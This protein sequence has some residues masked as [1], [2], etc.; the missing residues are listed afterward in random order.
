MSFR[1]IDEQKEKELEQQK[2]VENALENTRIYAK[3][4][5]ENLNIINDII[6]S[7]LWYM[8]FD[9]SGN[10]NRCV[11]SDTFRKM[12]GFN[13]IY[14]FPD[15][16]ESWSDRLHPEERDRI[17]EAY[18]NCVAGKGDY[19]VQYRLLKKDN[20]YTWYRAVGKVVRYTNGKPRLFAGTVVDI[21]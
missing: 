12:L 1:C 5:Q 9:E 7:G 19:D 8:E 6:G 3:R 17:I 15:K 13:D 2:A 20:K 11:W 18:W 10:M 21:T 14:D 4:A 16:L